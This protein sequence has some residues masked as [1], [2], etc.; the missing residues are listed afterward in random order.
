M[1]VDIFNTDKTYDIIY[2]DPP[3]QF[4]RIRQKDKG[5]VQKDII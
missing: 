5:G 1:K 2:A 3:W 4:G